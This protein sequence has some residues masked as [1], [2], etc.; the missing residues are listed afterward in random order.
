METPNKGNSHASC[1]PDSLQPSSTPAKN[2]SNL[3]QFL[4]Y[5]AEIQS[6]A[7]ST[8]KYRPCSTVWPYIIYT[9]IQP[10]EYNVTKS[11]RSR[12]NM[13]TPLHIP[14]IQLSESVESPAIDVHKKIEILIFHLRSHLSNEKRECNYQKTNPVTDNSREPGEFPHSPT[15]LVHR[16]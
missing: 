9:S 16:K 15:Q 3:F 12:C 8:W 6:M 14:L 2:K 5:L 1:S 7:Q 11:R 13:E 4:E 10:C